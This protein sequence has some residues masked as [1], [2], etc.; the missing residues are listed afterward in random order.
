M[1]SVRIVTCFCL[2]VFAASVFGFTPAE[3]QSL[4]SAP[5]DDGRI[6]GHGRRVRLG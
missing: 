2:S 1:S 6:G 4:L 3:A 5:V